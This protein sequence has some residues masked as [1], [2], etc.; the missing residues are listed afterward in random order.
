MTEIDISFNDEVDFLSDTRKKLE[1]L[2][3]GIDF[4]CQK[5]YQKN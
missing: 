5:E 2:D 3:R 1:N 4:K